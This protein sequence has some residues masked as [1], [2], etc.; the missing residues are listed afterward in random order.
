[1]HYF[2]QGLNTRMLDTMSMHIALSG[3]T[4]LQRVL[5]IANKSGSRRKEVVEHE[6]KQK[7]FSRIPVSWTV[8]FFWGDGC[9][10]VFFVF[11]VLKS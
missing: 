8:Y 3:Q 9:A 6:Q 10:I 4:S 11:K 5:Y 2:A 7:T 1:M